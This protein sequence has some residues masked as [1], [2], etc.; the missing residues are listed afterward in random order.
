MSYKH[1][2]SKGVTYYLNSKDVILKGGKPQRVYFF[3]KDDRPETGVDLP[4][5]HEVREN[6]RNGFLVLSKKK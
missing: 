4:D 6:E 3:S 5:T 2:N 1:V